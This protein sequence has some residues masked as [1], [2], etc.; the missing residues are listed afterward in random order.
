MVADGRA[1]GRAVWNGTVY[2]FSDASLYI[3]K[4]WGGAFPFKWYWAQCNSWSSTGTTPVRRLSITSGGGTRILP[5]GATEDLGMVCVHVDGT[6]YE[7]VPWTSSMRWEVEPW[8]SWRL[9]GRTIESSSAERPFEVELTVKCD[10]PGVKLRAPTKADGLAYFCRDS[11][12]GEVELSLWDLVR[13]PDGKYV[14]APDRPPVVD[15]ATG[16]QCAVEV[17]GGPWWDKWEDDAKMRE[18]MRT[19]VKAPYTLKKI[20]KWIGRTLGRGSNNGS[21]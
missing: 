19:M 13:G 4:N 10:A 8:G 1:S 9:S 6:F 7:A 20:K 12:E 18:P 16:F 3:E 21:K 14:R 15:R 17:G 5:L 11:F 2:D